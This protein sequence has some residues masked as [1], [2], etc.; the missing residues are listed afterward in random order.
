[1]SARRWRRS[2]RFGIAIPPWSAVLLAVVGGTLATGTS[3]YWPFRFREVGLES[4]QD[5]AMYAIPNFVVLAIASFSYGYVRRFLSVS[6]IFVICGIMSAGGVAIMA[7]AT[8][9][10]GIAWGLVLEGIGVGL[11][12]PNTSFY[13]IGLSP[14]ERRASMIGMVQGVNFG[15]PFLTQ[16]ALEWFNRRSGTSAA[17]LAIGAMALAMGVVILFRMI[18]Q[19]GADAP[20]GT[21]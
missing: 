10:L 11:L 17:L 8:T 12:V 2:P 6:A 15:S 14:P 1:M 4:A 5:I 20:V 21:R 16:F 9:P 19:R 7:L 3:L 18:R 13:T